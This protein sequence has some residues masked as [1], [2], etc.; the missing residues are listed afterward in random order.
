MLATAIIEQQKK[1][2][3]ETLNT[4]FSIEQVLYDISKIA[5]TLYENEQ[6]EQIVDLLSNVTFFK[7][8]IDDYITQFSKHT[9]AELTNK[10]YNLISDIFKSL[11]EQ[12]LDHP[13]S[14]F[15]NLKELPHAKVSRESSRNN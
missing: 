8:L 14:L 4:A 3:L 6:L 13:Y 7:D 15:L 5:G 11:E 9:T 1:I 2:P 10:I 12:K